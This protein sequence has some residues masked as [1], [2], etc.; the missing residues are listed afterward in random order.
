M[1]A[2]LGDG[3]PE[4]LLLQAAT[5]SDGSPVDEEVLVEPLGA[6]RY[7]LLRSP[8]LVL[9]MAAGD[10]FECTGKGGFQVITRGGNLCVQ[11]L[12]RSAPAGLEEQATRRLGGLG[13][14]LDGKA[15][16]ELVYT[17]PVSSGFASIERVL[18]ALVLEY[19]SVEWYYGNV[20][21]PKDGVTP[22]NWW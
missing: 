4:T 6:T 2:K 17:L 15:S 21:D 20:Y 18:N 11:L 3:M 7:R 1:V 14:K 10:V 22:L 19:P 5:K 16:M 13:G 12:F 9:G 8:G